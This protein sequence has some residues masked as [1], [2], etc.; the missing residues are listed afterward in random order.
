VRG[1]RLYQLIVFNT[2]VRTRAAR[3]QQR[4]MAQVSSDRNARLAVMVFLLME[5]IE[6]TRVGC[7][8]KVKVA[9]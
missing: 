9:D 3:R 1:E 5:L 6:N 7:A 8:R 4:R 2:P